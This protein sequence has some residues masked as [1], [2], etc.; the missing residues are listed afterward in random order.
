MNFQSDDLAAAIMAGNDAAMQWYALT[1]QTT[2]PVNPNQPI[3]EYSPGSGP[4]VALGNY[5]LLIIGA[6]LIG[7]FLLARD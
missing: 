7:I 3:V 6:I 1:H 5:G 4:R 2:I